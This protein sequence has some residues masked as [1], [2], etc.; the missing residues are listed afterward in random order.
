[1]KKSLILILMC[2]CASCVSAEIEKC[3]CSSNMV[4]QR[5]MSCENVLGGGF[6]WVN[7]ST[8]KV[9]W[10]DPKNN[11]W[12]YYGHPKGAH[13]GEGM[14]GR[15]IPYT[16]KNGPGLY[17]LNTITGEGWWT[18]GTVWKEMGIPKD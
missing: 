15:Y 12:V 2:V 4:T 17:I 6:F 7:T 11:E 18:D 1:M 14:Y 8:G 9:W 3:R 5:F 13:K 10:A 16:H